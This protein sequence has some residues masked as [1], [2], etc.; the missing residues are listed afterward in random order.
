MNRSLLLRFFFKEENPSAATMIIPKIS[1]FTYFPTVHS[2]PV[3]SHN[4]TK[5]AF[6]HQ[7]SPNCY[8]KQ[9]FRSNILSILFKA[10]ARYIG[11]YSTTSLYCILWW[12][13]LISFTYFQWQFQSSVQ[14]IL[15]GP[16]LHFLTWKWPPSSSS[17]RENRAETT[18]INLCI[19]PSSLKNA[20]HLRLF[21]LPIKLFL[22]K[23]KVLV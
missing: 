5:T 21:F 18:S 20:Q 11:F 22:T 9:S 1:L 12:L 4:S 8:T 13:I 3:G 14:Y 2:S 6:S 15:L 16:F 23:E 19:R 10:F 7:L 17:K